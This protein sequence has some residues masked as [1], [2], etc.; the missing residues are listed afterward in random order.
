MTVRRFI[1]CLAVCFSALAAT[2]CASVP[3]DANETERASEETERVRS[4]MY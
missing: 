3:R 2:A 1:A 4:G